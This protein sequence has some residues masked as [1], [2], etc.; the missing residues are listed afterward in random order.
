[1]ADTATFGPRRTV[2]LEG[3]EIV[4]LGTAHISQASTDEVIA[5]ISSGQY[6]AVAV[7]LCESRLR[8]LTDQHYLENLDLFQVIRAGRGGLIMANLALGAYQQRLAEQLGVDPGAELRAAAQQAETNGAELILIDREVATTMRRLYRNVPW[9]Q[10]L[11]LI[12]GLIASM[13][14]SQK[15]ESAD[16]ERLKKG[17][18]MESTFRE[19]AQSSSALYK[20]LIEERDRYMA[21]RLLAECAGKFRKVLVVLGAGHLEGVAAALASP[22]SEPR[23]EVKELDTCPPP[24]AWPKILAWAVVVIILSGFAIGF[25]RSPDLGWALVATW[26]LLNGGLS[27]L[28][29]ALAYGHP[30]TVAGAFCAAPLTSLN[31]TIGAGFVAAA[32]EIGVRRPRVGDFRNLRKHV[33]RWQGWW[34][35]RVARTLLVFLFA[36]IGSAAGTYLA[37][38]R[39][40]ERLIST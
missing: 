15:I 22:V 26:V 18:I 2:N 37:G 33:T 31:P 30:V 32:I 19:M 21:A 1:M 3:T 36:S 20:P 23:K 27:A 34:T 40:I 13:I 24:S 38:A 6:D 7:E 10:R 16:V 8:S 14:T 17:D 35:N 9:Y 11:G 25:S 12:S 29:T 39:I 5:E 4:L 28:G